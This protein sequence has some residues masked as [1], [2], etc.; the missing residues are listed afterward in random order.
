MQ[1]FLTEG[2]VTLIP[3]SYS[4]GFFAAV[5]KNFLIAFLLRIAFIYQNSSFE[6]QYSGP[7]GETVT[8][9]YSSPPADNSEISWRSGLDISLYWWHKV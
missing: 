1:V 5:E 6:H 8:L 9:V 7:P 2:L 4:P 3:S